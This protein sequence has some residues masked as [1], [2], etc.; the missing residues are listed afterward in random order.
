[1]RIFVAS[2]RIWAPTFV[3]IISKQGNYVDFYGCESN[4]NFNDNVTYFG[5]CFKKEDAVIQFLHNNWQQYDFICM[6][7]YNWQINFEF[8]KLKEIVSVPVLTPSFEANQLERDKLFSKKLFATLNIPTPDYI[9]YTSLEQIE[10]LGKDKF[11]FKLANDFT[12]TGFQTMIFTD[13]NYKNIIPRYFKNGY[14]GK[15][16]IEDF[17]DGKEAV[18]HF[19]CNGKSNLYLGAS[20]DYK[21]VKDNDLGFNVSSTGSY[22]PVEYVTNG[23]VDK[24]Q[25]YIS[26][27]QTELD[28]VGI[29]CVGIILDPEPKILEINVRPG[30]PEFNTLLLTL[31]PSCLLDNF[32]SAASRKPFS[33]ISINS[34]HCVTLQ[35]LHHNYNLIPKKD[36]IF[37]SSMPPALS[38]TY[39]EKEFHY[40]NYYSSISAVS[41]TRKDAAKKIYNEINHLDLGDYRYRT[42]IGFLD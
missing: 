42:D 40:Y 6:P 4:I 18:L 8:Q 25:G 5:S 9:E 32:I 19:L 3:D 13:N 16:Y 2:V 26:K 12:H 31:D 17:V 14:Q 39:F 22:S 15:S 34:Q 33:T 20:R 10:L 30:T 11:V 37:P 23:I 29:M 36:A 24:I 21:K 28:Y 35:T 27:I 41:S 1:M 7:D 38:V